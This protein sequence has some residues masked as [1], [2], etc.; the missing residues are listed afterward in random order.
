M[1]ASALW[2]MIGVRDKEEWLLL[3]F[4]SVTRKWACADAEE[5]DSVT[6]SDS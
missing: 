6:S 4:D 3:R 1:W 2:R 5:R